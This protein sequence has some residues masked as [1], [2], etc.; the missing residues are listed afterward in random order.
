LKCFSGGI[1]D[2]G[3][4]LKSRRRLGLGD[5][6]S[7]IHEFNFI[8]GSNASIRVYCDNDGWTVMQS[9]GQFGNIVNYFERT[10][11]AYKKGFGMPGALIGNIN[12]QVCQG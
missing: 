8:P 7:G 10:W 1:L 9:R 5:D 4:L 12:M 6:I 11:T 2:C 3:D